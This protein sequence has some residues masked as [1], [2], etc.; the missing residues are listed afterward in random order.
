LLRLRLLRLDLLGV[1]LLGVGLLGVSLLRIGLLR[2]SLHHHALR[3]FKWDRRM[4]VRRLG[5]SGR[6]R[7]RVP[8]VPPGGQLLVAGKVA[9]N[10]PQFPGMALR[11]SPRA[12][13]LMFPAEFLGL[14]G[15]VAALRRVAHR[16]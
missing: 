4:V 1:G 16:G 2:F 13:S 8:V 12:M 10:G 7:P 11:Q 9:V 14:G 15:I 6:G 3:R 5:G